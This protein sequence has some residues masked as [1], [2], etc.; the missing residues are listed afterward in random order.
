LNGI[1]KTQLMFQ[2]PGLDLQNK[3]NLGFSR[4]AKQGVLA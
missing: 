1:N 3:A 4:F 2:I